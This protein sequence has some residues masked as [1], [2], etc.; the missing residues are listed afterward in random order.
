MDTECLATQ[1]Q[2]KASNATLLRVGRDATQKRNL[3]CEKGKCYANAMVNSNFVRNH[4]HAWGMH[5]PAHTN[6]RTNANDYPNAQSI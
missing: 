4:F 1:L 3:V 2:I 6:A 5:A